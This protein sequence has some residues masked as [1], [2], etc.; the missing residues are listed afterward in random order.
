MKP[1][2]DPSHSKHL[3]TPAFI[4]RYNRTFLVEFQRYC[5]KC[6]VRYEIKKSK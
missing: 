5:C 3:T 6:D 4:E 1:T 2:N